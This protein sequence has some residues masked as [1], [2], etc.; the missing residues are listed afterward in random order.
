MSLEEK[1]DFLMNEIYELK[2]K[3]EEELFF[4]AVTL[5]SGKSFGEIALIKNQP[6]AASIKTI[7]ECHFAV[8]SK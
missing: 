7:E 8:M 3:E 4:E 1:K 2:N 6:R 5:R